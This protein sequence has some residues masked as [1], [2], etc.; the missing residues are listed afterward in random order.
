MNTDPV[1][2]VHHA[3]AIS[4]GGVL[5]Y[6]IFVRPLV[7]FW[8]RSQRRL[9]QQPVAGTVMIRIGHF[10][11][12]RILQKLTPRF[13]V[14]ACTLHVGDKSVFDVDFSARKMT[15]MISRTGDDTVGFWR[16]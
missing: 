5:P 15:G 16:R 11:D 12:S 4:L 3:A 13:G 2:V 10:V 6:H 9:V 14:D 8:V 1:A 7:K